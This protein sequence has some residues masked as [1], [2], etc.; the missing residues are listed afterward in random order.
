MNFIP[1]WIEVSEVPLDKSLQF[2]LHCKSWGFIQYHWWHIYL[3]W[4]H[5]HTNWYRSWLSRC[6]KLFCL[7]WILLSSQSCASQI[8][9]RYPCHLI[10]VHPFY[11][12]MSRI[13]LNCY[14][15]HQGIYGGISIGRI[16][17]IRSCVVCWWWKSRLML[18]CLYF[19]IRKN[20]IPKCLDQDSH[21]HSHSGNSKWMSPAF[22]NNIHSYLLFMHQF[23]SI[24][25]HPIFHLPSSRKQMSA[26]K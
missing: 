26:P 22:L 7:W 20:I 9:T 6:L 8:C 12:T 4:L 10:Y 16:L 13:R 18:R 3:C 17:Q 23:P 24:S 25:R 2:Y 14:K 5:Y 11:R 21:L 15:T 1:H 19:G